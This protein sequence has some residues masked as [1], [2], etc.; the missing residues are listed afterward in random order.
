MAIG[1]DVVIASK[2]GGDS[3]ITGEAGSIP[4]AHPVKIKRIIMLIQ[5]N[6]FILSLSF[7]VLSRV[8]YLKGVTFAVI[9]VCDRYGGWWKNVF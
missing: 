6:D 1:V 5:P 9:S 8:V 2:V 7:T 3:V 4:D